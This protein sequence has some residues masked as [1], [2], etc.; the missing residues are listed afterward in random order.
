MSKKHMGSTIDDFLKKE[1]IF[2]EAQPI[3]V[4]E[5]VCLAAG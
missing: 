2:G 1:G 5:V 3:A 4:K